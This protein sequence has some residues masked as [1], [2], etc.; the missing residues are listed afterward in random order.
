MNART[1]SVQTL[2]DKGSRPTFAV[3]PFADYQAFVGNQPPAEPGIPIEVV[4]Y[5]LE[6]AW[7]AARAWREHKELTQT[8]VA[9]RMGITQGAYAQLEA[10]TRI[11]HIAVVTGC[12]RPDAQTSVAVVSNF[13]IM[14]RGGHGT[15]MRWSPRAE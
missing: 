1:E 5:A 14:Q 8:E 7:S 4:G 3:L 10:K 12:P 9:H 15:T 11:W 13:A 6:Y 2:R